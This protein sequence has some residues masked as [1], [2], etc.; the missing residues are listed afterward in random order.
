M[1]ERG[2]GGSGLREQEED[3]SAAA[4]DRV[5]VGNRNSS[6]S[7]IASF[8]QSACLRRKQELESRRFFSH[9]RVT[10]N[11]KLQ[12]QVAIGERTAMSLPYPY[13]NGM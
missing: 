11:L 2:S 5:Y 8:R 10:T 9:I 13:G 1:C 12:Q 3:R 6:P 4:S 7:A